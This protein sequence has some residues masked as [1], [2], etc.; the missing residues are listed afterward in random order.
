MADISAMWIHSP[1]VMMLIVGLMGGW[2]SW[3]NADYDEEFCKRRLI[4]NLITGVLA[5]FMVPL[6]LQ[7]I[8]SNLLTDISP[9][10]QQF[11]VFL[12]MCSAAAF[13][14][15]KFASSISEQLLQKANNKA[16]HAEAIAKENSKKTIS[17][18]IEQLKLQ[19]S[20]SLLKNEFEKALGY[21]DAYL[22]HQPNDVNSLWRKA[23][24]L[25][26]LG[27]KDVALQ[28]IDKAITVSQNSGKEIS[29]LLFF[30]RACYKAL[31]SEKVGSI[32]ND[33][34]KSMSIDSVATIRNIK[35]DLAEDF[36]NIRN[37]PQF[38]DF[39]DKYEIKESEVD[40]ESRE[41]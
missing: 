31:L 30:N 9:Q 33:L 14:A 8:G 17:L 35:N 5:T 3:L 15:Q 34:E 19:G 40:V 20:I 29:A 7:M 24:C 22:E 26:R 37:E 10:Y 6:F 1:F 28:V 41:Q 39:L 4:R 21:L 18:E 36:S 38:V 27:R 2:L 12:G 32:V 11:Y 16:E 25:K 23:F 13:V